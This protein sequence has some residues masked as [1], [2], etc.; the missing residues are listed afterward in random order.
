MIRI[1]ATSR[2]PERFEILERITQPPASVALTLPDQG[3]AALSALPVGLRGSSL[4]DRWVSI[5]LAA[6]LPVPAQQ[7]GIST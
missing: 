3:R 2:A 1:V 4:T 5:K 6:R 7:A